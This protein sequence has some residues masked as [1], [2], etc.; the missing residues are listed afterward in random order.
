MRDPN[1]DFPFSANT[2]S[3]RGFGVFAVSRHG[4]LR[5]YGT[6]KFGGIPLEHL[7]PR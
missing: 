1:Y 5:L 6:A 2:K 7:Q 3:R 4:S